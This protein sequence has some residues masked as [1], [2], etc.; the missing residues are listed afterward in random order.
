MLKNYFK[1][2]LRNIA[3]NKGCSLINI[4]GLA[5]GLAVCILIMLWVQDELSYDRW[6]HNA[7]NTYLMMSTQQLN[8][9][10]QVITTQQAP[11][12]P[13]LKDNIPEIMNY[14]RY[15][16]YDMPISYG[17]KSFNE[18]LCLADSSYFS[19]FTFPLVE[20]DSLKALVDPHSVVIT[21]QL[22][23]KYFGEEE[24]LGK[25]LTLRDRVPLTV[26]GVMRNIPENSSLQ[27]EMVIPFALLRE[28]GVDINEWKGSD[29]YTYLL[30]KKD[31]DAAAVKEKIQ[32][33]SSSLYRER[34]EKEV[35]PYIISLVPLSTLHL[36]GYWYGGG[37][38]QTVYIMLAV[39]V[40]IL[41]IACMNFINISTA[42]STIRA[43]E[44][45]LRKVAG[46]HKG[47]L[48]LQF[49]SEAVLL[50]CLALMLALVLVEL[51]LP[52]FNEIA[53][54]N[55][56]LGL[57]DW[58]LLSYFLFLMV[59]TGILSGAY[60]AFYISRFQPVKVLKGVFKSGRGSMRFRR[61]LVVAQF[62]LSIGI[63]VCML[64][65][66]RQIEYVKT[67]DLGYDKNNVLCFRPTGGVAEH[68]EAFKKELLKDP[69]VL[70]VTSSVQNIVHVN[71]TIGNNWSWE[72]RDPSRKLEIHFD[73]VSY[74]YA[75]TMK[76]EIAEGRFYSPDFPSDTIDGLVVNESLV[77]L[78]G[79]KDPIGKKISYWGRDCRIIGVVNDFHLEPLYETLKPMLLIYSSDHQVV[80]VR[81]NPDKLQAALVY[82][83]QVYKEFEPT[84]TFR[85]F[86]LNDAYDTYYMD[87]VRLLTVFK[88]ATGL[89]IFVS[90]LGLFGLV[91]YLAEQ[92][93][94]E[95]GIRKVLG[96]SV[97]SII[98]LLTKEFV[99]L[100]I[101]AN[102]VA[103]PLAYLLMNRLLER[104]AYRID[105]GVGGFILSGLLILTVALVTISYQAVRAA[106]TDPV[107]ALRHE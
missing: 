53:Q 76:M 91:A 46:A 11:L 22:A 12:A 88:Y 72:G 6:H 28:F 106:L 31:T 105:I 71:S 79:I 78:A 82:I 4:A 23:R 75:K 50:A 40:V 67:K 8:T 1:I 77:R 63:T 26:T 52:V 19:V 89:T 101:T 34:T 100:V 45:G 69:G 25:V 58:K 80:Y 66:F 102:L 27:Y 16:V 43:K 95:I 37:S 41:V 74:D 65:L 62:T 7:G 64:V 84:G 68:Y 36:Q 73:W 10:E 107:K 42:R 17:E 35:F 103:W 33:L 32:N 18:Q 96:A 14:V 49:L 29:Y 30:L 94:R 2:A 56:G 93:T 5:I 90:C 48:I 47:D 20:G 60:T 3:R 97:A 54:K 44:V 70:D 51:A 55:L 59:V 39:A 9:G 21:E 61:I 15:F 99:L 13:I 38:L 85:A 57:T 104:Y 98:R 92:R 81:I 87:E 86:F 24:P 83:K